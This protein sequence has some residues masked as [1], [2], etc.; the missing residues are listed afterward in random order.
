MESIIETT[1]SI[2]IL[3]LNQGLT[4]GPTEV[5]MGNSDVRK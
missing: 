1:I 4:S 5:N 3:R 2:A